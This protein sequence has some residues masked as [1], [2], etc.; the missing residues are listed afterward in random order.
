MCDMAKPYP[1]RRRRER[2]A[3]GRG[4]RHRHD[5][6]AAGERR[7]RASSRSAARPGA[8][9]AASPSRSFGSKGSI[10]FDQERFNEFQLYLAGERPTEAGF[11][12]VLAAPQH[13]PYDRFIPVPG[14]GLG[15]NDL[16]TIE[17]RQLIG[18]MRGE[19]SSRSTFEEGILI[20][21][22]VDAMARSFRKGAGSRSDFAQRHGR[23]CPL[24]AAGYGELTA[25]RGGPCLIRVPPAD[26]RGI[27]SFALKRCLLAPCRCLPFSLPALAADPDPARWDAVLAEARGRPSISTPGAAARTSTPMSNGRAPSSTGATASS[28]CM[29]SSTTPPNA[30]AKVVAEKSVGK[31][32]RRQRRPDL[33]Q[34]REFRCDEAAASAALAGLGGKTAQLADM[35]TTADN[36][37]VRTDFTDS[38]RRAGKPLGHGEAGVLP[39]RGQHA[40]R[41]CRNRPRNCSTGPR[42]TRAASPIRSRRISSVRRS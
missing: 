30:V 4:V 27:W 41:R 15:F 31:D 13:R 7:R 18:R 36:P 40:G 35:S 39:R 28:S 33:D 34:R 21:R 9:R 3:R 6:A 26:R 17:C 38:R 8:A 22:T 25:F 12:T 42:P 11:R 20:E 24:A 14:H 29:S 16:K 5:P 19:D 23:N 10:L 37:T 1:T 32:E 2:R